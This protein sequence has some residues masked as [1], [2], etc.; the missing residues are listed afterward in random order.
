MGNK[1]KLKVASRLLKRQMTKAIRGSIARAATEPI[2]NSDD[3]YR[4]LERKGIEVPGIILIFYSR[5]QSYFAVLDQAE[6]MDA[7][8]LEENLSEYGAATSGAKTGEDVRGFFGKGVK[9]T[10]Y[11]LGGSEYHCFKDG[12]YAQAKLY[13]ENGDFM[14]EGEPPVPATEEVRRPF[15]I[16]GNGTFAKF[17]IPEDASKPWYE[18]LREQISKMYMLRPILASEARSVVLMDV[19]RLGEPGRIQRLQYIPPAGHRLK[20]AEEFTVTYKSTSFLIQLDLWEADQ[21]LEQRKGDTREGGL[22]V[23]DEKGAVLDLTLFRFDK[24]PLAARLFGSLTIHGFRQLLNSEEP[25]LTDSR[26]GLDPDHPFV[27]AL[28]DEVEKRLDEYVSQRRK[29]R[30][31]SRNTLSRATREKFMATIAKLNQIAEEETKHEWSVQGDEPNHEPPA[32]PLRFDYTKVRLRV[33][34]PR[35]IGLTIDQGACAGGNVTLTVDPKYVEVT[36]EVVGL[37]SDT[38]SLRQKLLLTARRGGAEVQLVASC[39]QYSAVCAIQTEDAESAAYPA[40]AG[41]LDFE[42][43]KYVVRDGKGAKLVLYA[44]LNIIPEG[45]KITL[46]STDKA[47][48]LDASEVVVDTKDASASVARLLV[49]CYV[50]GIGRSAIVEAKWEQYEALTEV[51]VTS[52]ADK[53]IRTPQGSN[54]LFTNIEYDDLSGERERYHYDES[55]GVIY[56][57]TKHP[58]MRLYL[59]QND[60]PEAPSIQVITAEL[61]VQ[62][63]CEEIARRQVLSGVRAYLSPDPARR[64]E[65]DRIFQTDLGLKYSEQIHRLLVFPDQGGAAEVAA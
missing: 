42:R 53:P 10:S 15:G 61:V 45:S 22:L 25:V 13:Q 48:M 47:V 28:T 6:G 49:P 21:D 57:H 64:A 50:S 56:I 44:D 40:P 3:S 55:N 43:D 2:T 32:Q 11:A 62:C 16:P 29:E 60:S 8:K 39:G 26:D 9:D 33:D 63:V 36:P 51:V 1:K 31:S 20:E 5:Q 7:G 41:G 12:E 65:E 54:G 18:T 59:S 4:R 46:S 37:T 35:V 19:D 14:F 34:E 24:E 23:S 17:I 52:A 58:T 30:R 27:Q 38:G